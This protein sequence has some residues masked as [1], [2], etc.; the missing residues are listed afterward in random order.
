MSIE[1]EIRNK[2]QNIVVPGAQRSLAQLNLIRNFEI[3]SNNIRLVLASTGLSRRIQNSLRSMI[4][5]SVA[6]LADGRSTEIDFADS[7]PRQ[8]NEIRHVVAIVSGKGGVG[9]SL[10]TG[11]SAVSLER[12]GYHMGILDAD[13]TGPSIP[14][15]F[16]ITMHPTG[17][18]NAILPVV[19]RGGIA[20]MSVNLLMEHGDDALIW[21]GSIISNTIKQFWEDVLWG[22]LDYL[23]VDLPPGT[24]DAALTVI[25]ALPLSGVVIVF[26]PENLASMVVRKAIKMAWDKHITIL[27]V[28]ENMSYLRLPETGARIELFGK[29]RGKEMAEAA[30]APLLGQIPMEPELARL[31]G[32][33]NIESS[34][35][36]AAANVADALVRI[37]EGA[38]PQNG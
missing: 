16:G 30:R 29:S 4:G 28:V 36:E 38:S 18:H 35:S 3:S 20:I 17:S 5:D 9:K 12:R 8:I 2:L 19:S 37:V 34:N 21:R 26:T 25:E 6:T 27:G 24:S 7:S 32:E 14:G 10:V 1:A 15:M 13:I 33:G 31:C 11:L 23:L 22:R